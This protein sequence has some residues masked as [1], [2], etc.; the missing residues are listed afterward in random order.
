MEAIQ[1]NIML[2][3]FG[4]LGNIGSAASEGE[5]LEVT[6]LEDNFYVR[7]S[8]GDQLEGYYIAKVQNQNNVPL[9][10]NDGAIVLMD[11]DGNEVGKAD[12]MS[13][14]GSRYLEPGEI[15]YVSLRADAEGGTPVAYE[16]SIQGTGSI[17]GT[18]EQLEAANPELR[19]VENYGW[20]NY[21]VGAT[22]TNTGDAPMSQ[23]N[24]VIAIRDTN[25]KLIDLVQAGLYQNEL[26]AGSTITLLDSVDSTTID[27]CT[28]NGT[29]L[30]EVEA[31]AW[32]EVAN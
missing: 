2:T 8:W 27:Y 6:V 14:S 29:D 10:I 30:G 12:Y 25:G 7:K 21:Y 4:M 17:Y 23:V 11:A 19:K 18:D 13:R 22:N 16:A 9:N 24:A 31:F 15:S 1:T 26:A 32:M 5:A 28:E 3:L 20:A